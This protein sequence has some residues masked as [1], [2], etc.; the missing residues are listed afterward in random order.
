MNAQKVVLASTNAGKIRE[1][2]AIL[3]PMNIELLSMAEFNIPSIE[4][5]YDTFVEN[6]LAKARAVS[7][8]TKLPALADD[9]GLCVLALDY[10]PGVQSAHFAGK[11][12]SD[13]ANNQKL[14]SMLKD[15][16]NRHAFFYCVLVM[17]QAENDPQP[18]IVDG[19]WF[20][21]IAYKPVG[22][23]GFGYDPIFYPDG[24]TVTSAQLDLEQKNQ[25]SHRAIALQKLI[26]EVQHLKKR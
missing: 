6:A 24:Q 18:I 11:N 19:R 7:A 17:V 20:G 12:A 21:K 8:Y 15:Q 4:E 14:L 23:N 25:M 13:Q 22:N 3:E 10:Q 26:E 2:R 1:I 16:E 5:P 9:S